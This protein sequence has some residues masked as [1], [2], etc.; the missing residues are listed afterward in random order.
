MLAGSALEANHSRGFLLSTAVAA[1][2]AITLLLLPILLGWMRG[3]ARPS[4]GLATCPRGPARIAPL[5]TARFDA[6][7]IGWQGAPALWS[8]PEL[9]DAGLEVGPGRD[10]AATRREAVDEEM[11]QR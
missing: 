6:D 11:R 2:S 1:C 7:A 9:P 8:S 3:W 10:D 5:A 4:A